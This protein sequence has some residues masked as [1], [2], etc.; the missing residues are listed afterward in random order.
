MLKLKNISVAFNGTPVLKNLSAV[1][2][3]G[4]SI[5]LVG[6]NG[7][8]KSTLFNVIAG[9]IIPGSGQILIDGQDCTQLP[10]RKRA[11]LLSCL[12][13][14]PRENTVASM[15]VAEN[16]ALAFYKGKRAG[17]RNGMSVMKAHKHVL[18]LLKKLHLDGLLE[19]QMGSLSGGQRQLIA[20]IMATVVPPKILLLDEPTA[21]LD[22]KAAAMLISFVRE[23][24]K[25]HKIATILI[26]HDPAIAASFGERVWRMEA[27]ALTQ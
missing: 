27:G 8:G 22:K 15:T 17:L 5:V 12:E 24:I 11:V 9:F 1:V 6:D 13:Q 10:A 14:F 20:F 16:I 26:T 3:A 23:Y 2:G 19:K 18:A 4:E 21:A 7:S 25:E